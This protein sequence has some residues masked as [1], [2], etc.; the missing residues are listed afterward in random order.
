[1]LPYFMEGTFRYRFH[2]SPPLSHIL[3]QIKFTHVIPFYFFNIHFNI[4]L[5]S[6]SNITLANSKYNV[7]V[8]NKTL[9]FHIQQK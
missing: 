2:N 5:S 4:I 3:S 9:L 7:S 8:N 1:M 6:V